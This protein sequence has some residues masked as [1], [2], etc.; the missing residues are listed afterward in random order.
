MGLLDVLRATLRE[1]HPDMWGPRLNRWLRDKHRP[2]DV[3]DPDRTVL[4]GWCSNGWTSKA[5][6]WPCDE[7]VR[8]D[9][10]VSDERPRQYR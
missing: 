2:L 6:E 10:L 4:C 1:L 5:V 8:L 3:G 9:K 7:Y